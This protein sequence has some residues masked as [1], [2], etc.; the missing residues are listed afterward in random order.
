MKFLNL[1]WLSVIILFF[2]SLSQT[3]SAQTAASGTMRGVEFYEK[4]EY[5]SAMETLQK[6]VAVDEKDRVAWLYLGT[7]AARLN[8]AEQA[9]K[10]FKKVNKLSLVIFP[11]EA[12]GYN[13]LEVTYQKAPS[14]TELARSNGTKGK[15]K[16]AVEFGADGKISFMHPFVTLPDGLTEQAIVAARKIKFKPA[17]KNGKPVSV[18]KVVEFNF[19]M[20]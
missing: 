18:I 20:Y 17:T 12:D 5:K 1:I 15:V 11:T 7:A 19:N 8:D 13:P 3:V 2:V 10:A 9:R 6:V 16:I 4:G 14:Y